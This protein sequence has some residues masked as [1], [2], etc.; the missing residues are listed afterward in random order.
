MTSSSKFYCLS[1]EILTAI[2]E[3][4]VKPYPSWHFQKDLPFEEYVPKPHLWQ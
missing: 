1:E 3:E 4:L 2:V